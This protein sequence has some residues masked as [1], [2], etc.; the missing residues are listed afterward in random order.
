M[1]RQTERPL[2]RH[3]TDATSRGDRKATDLGSASPRSNRS[4]AGTLDKGM[5][6]GEGRENKGKFP[7]LSGVAPQPVLRVR[8]ERNR[9]D[10]FGISLF[11]TW[12]KLAVKEC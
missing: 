5:E 4:E 6:E 7:R 10:V 3:L 11:Y 8:K 1:Q 9:Q 12:Q 2:F